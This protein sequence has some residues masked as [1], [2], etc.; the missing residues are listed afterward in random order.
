MTA[1]QRNLILLGPPGAGKGTQAQRL[2]ARWGIPQISTGDMLR[3]ARR[4]G[5]ELGRK[6]AA[7]M[8]AGGLVSDD[9][10]VALVEERLGR[11]DA[12]DG[13]IFDGF[14]RTIPQAEAL[15]RLLERMGRSPVRVVAIDV[16]REHL[17]ERLSGRRSCPK[18]GAAYHVKFSPPKREGFCDND[19]TPLVQ[20]EDDRPEAVVKRLEEYRLKTA[21][22]IDYYRPRGVLRIV[23]GVGELET[24]LE[25][26][27]RA[28]E[29]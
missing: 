22:L 26:I 10:V 23:D 28:L 3:E 11:S 29:G 18:D 13:A 15:D 19:G 21:P 5:S 2:A 9:L 20:R 16:S 6:V 4:A 25:R 8:D 7:V 24:V 27:T 1:T 17:V 12:R 14:P